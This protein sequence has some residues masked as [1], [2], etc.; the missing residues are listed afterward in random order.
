MGYWINAF[1]FPVD[2][3]MLWMKRRK[4]RR[5]ARY[6]R[7]LERLKRRFQMK[8][9]VNCEDDDGKTDSDEVT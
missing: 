2:L 7:K 6:R 8:I 5:K 4:N 1:D 3:Y 9:Y